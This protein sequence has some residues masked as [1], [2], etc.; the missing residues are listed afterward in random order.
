M[1]VYAKSISTFHEQTTF[2]M[3]RCA[4]DA[5]LHLTFICFCD[6]YK[7]L[8]S[9]KTS[10]GLQDSGQAITVMASAILAA[11]YVQ[12]IIICIIHN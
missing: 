12:L 2:C 3:Y 9:Y 6:G 11:F 7:I 4:V 1:I 8:V 5:F 10:S